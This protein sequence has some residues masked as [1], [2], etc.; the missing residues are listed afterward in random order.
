M[1]ERALYR[2]LCR[3]RAEIRVVA[4]HWRQLQPV[5]A[6]GD[7]DPRDARIRR[8]ARLTVLWAARL[9]LYRQPAQVA[10]AAGAMI[11]LPLV[12]ALRMA[13]LWH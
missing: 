13:G 11:G 8:N 3:S 4:R 6:D 10:L 7:P 12:L 1:L 2:W 9:V 5:A